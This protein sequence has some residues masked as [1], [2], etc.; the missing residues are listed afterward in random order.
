[1]DRAF[2]ARLRCPLTGGP[3][4]VETADGP[5]EIRHGLLRSDGGLFPVVAGIP[6]LEVSQRA[7]DAVAALRRGRPDEALLRMVQPSW[8]PQPAAATWLPGL[9]ATLAA[10]RRAVLNG[11]LRPE[12][13]ACQLFDA[14]FPARWPRLREAFNYLYYRF[15]QPRHLVSLAFATLA[16]EGPV[17]DVG[18]GAGHVARYLGVRV[19]VVGMDRDFALLY[20]SRRIVAPQVPVVC[21]DAERRFPFPDRSFPVVYSSDVLYA[22][23]HKA[24]VV[25]EFE[26][27]LRPGG[28][29]LVTALR[30]SA[31]P[32][33]AGHPI[34]P[35]AY[36]RL[37]SRWPRRLVADDRVLEAYLDR[38]GP[39]L[40]AVEP[41]GDAE[42]FSLVAAGTEELFRRAPA[43]FAD[44]PHAAGRLGFN[45]LYRVRPLPGG[46]RLTLEPPS[47][48]WEAEH[49]ACRRYMPA[50]VTV[51]DAVLRA[52]EQGAR[53]ET[54]EA[55]VAAC[56]LVDLPDRYGTSS[57]VRRLPGLLRRFRAADPFAEPAISRA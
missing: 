43:R 52:L 49:A 44:W 9:S 11:F 54:V 31:R 23:R 45:P 42:T 4:A 53:T 32:D 10:R 12:A 20:V 50:E 25:G 36:D 55:L 8:W 22:L 39:P 6:V 17:L 21:A 35:E 40:A 29:I 41:L 7:V 3:L 51:P 33:A 18:S 26:R 13:T 47:P 14:C 24:H 28:R 38:R 2:V 34:S 56:V 48:A 5:G 15:G 16:E 1:M 46:V 19:P 57:V 27:V 37:F 30:N